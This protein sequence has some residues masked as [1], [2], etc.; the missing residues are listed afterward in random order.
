LCDDIVKFGS[1]SESC[2]S[3]VNR[4]IES[5][6]VN[7]DDKNQEAL[8]DKTTSTI[9]SKRLRRKRSKGRPSNQQLQ[10]AAQPN[11]NVNI[12]ESLAT[13]VKYDETKSRE[14][15]KAN[16]FDGDEIVCQEIVRQ[17]NEKKSDIIMK[18]IKVLGKKK[19]LELLYATQDIQDNGGMF[20]KD[21][22]RKK[23]AGGIF[24]ELLKSDETI[25]NCQRKSI[26]MDQILQKKKNKTRKRLQHKFNLKSN[27]LILHKESLV[28]KDE[29]IDPERMNTGSTSS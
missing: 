26:F 16:E 6:D 14:H 3:K 20:T 1:V 25:L 12:L 7:Y 19:C 13:S 23:Y 27:E 18:C 24:F 21:G 28:N 15:I 10:Q 8:R 5:Y 11:E 2:R 29:P 17:L 9:K 4:D 22:L